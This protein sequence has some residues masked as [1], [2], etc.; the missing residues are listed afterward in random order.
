[1]ITAAQIAKSLY[2]ASRLARFDAGGLQ[3]FDNNLEEFWRS[4]FAAVI[5]A[6]MITV[7]VV[8]QLSEQTVGAG[9][10]R[11]FFAETV[12]YVLD[13]MIFP[14][15]ALYIADFIDRGDR[16]FRYIAA[17][18]WA[19][20]LQMALFLFIALLSQS[21]ML[22]QGLAVTLSIASTI[23]ILIYQGFITKVGL[24]VSTRAA[25]AIVFLD[26][27]IGIILNSTTIWMIQ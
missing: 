15:I 10:I 14:F 2:G 4:F 22:G 26:L 20:V 27:M 12:I 23:A 9:P 13:W 8:I 3:F 16:Y 18:N 1:M 19:I 17:R 6:P 21:G 24:E 7:L 5:V 11:I 25:A